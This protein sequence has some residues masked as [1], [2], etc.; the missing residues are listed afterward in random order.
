MLASLENKKKLL[1]T[2][3]V[4]KKNFWIPSWLTKK[5]FGFHDG[6]KKNF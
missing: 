3:L 6:L 1:D 4:D 5:T 2:I